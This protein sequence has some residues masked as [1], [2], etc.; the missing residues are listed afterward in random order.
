MIIGGAQV[1]AQM[2]CYADQ[3]HLSC[4]DIDVGRES[5]DEV[6]PDFRVTHGRLVRRV[7]FAAEDAGP[8]F[9]VSTWERSSGRRTERV[10]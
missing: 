9:T 10:V 5:G 8:G 7:A 6:F 1:Y 4:I 2:L 3:I